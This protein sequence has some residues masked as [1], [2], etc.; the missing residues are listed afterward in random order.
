MKTL[1]PLQN[2]EQLP[3]RGPPGIKGRK[4][5]YQK[6]NEA[7]HLN[8]KSTFWTFLVPV[9]CESLGYKSDLTMFTVHLGT[10]WWQFL[11]VEVEQGS[12]FLDLRNISQVNSTFG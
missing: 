4:H 5:R 12:Q 9:S 1:L 7:N 6:K 2:S 3:G 11:S 8:E 10:A